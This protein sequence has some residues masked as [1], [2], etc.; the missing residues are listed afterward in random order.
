MAAEDMTSKEFED[1]SDEEKELLAA[2]ME[3]EEEAEKERAEALDGLAASIEAK[4]YQRAVRR[5]NKELEWRKCMELY[6]GNLSVDSFT[7][8]DTPFTEASKANTKPYYNVVASK[9]DI[10]IAQSIDLQ[11]AGGEKNWSL[12]ADVTEKDP[13]NLEGSR[14]MEREIQAQ[15]ER[16][17]YGRKSRRAIE[18]RVI[19]GSGILKGPVNTGKLYDAWVPIEGT[20]LWAPAAAVDNSPSIERVNPWFFYPDDTV[21]EFCQ[22]TDALEVH[23]MSAFELARLRQHPG[24]IPD[25]LAEVLKTRPEQYLN[26]SFSDYT[27]ITES[28]PY[29]FND[30]YLVI[31]YHGPILADD[32][33]K[34]SIERPAY[35]SLNGEYYGEVWVCNGKVI[36]IELEN[37]EAS[38]EIP[39]ALSTWKKDPASVFGFGSPLLMKDAQRVVREIWRMILDNA[40]I[41]SGPQV[42]LHRTYVEPA[43][44]SW[45][46]HPGKSW[47]LL[48]SSIDVQKAIQFFDV[49]NVT[50]QLLPILDRARAFAEEESMTPMI[51]GGLQGSDLSESASGQLLMKEASTTILDFLAEDWDDNITEKVIRRMYAWNMQ[52]NPR[53]DIKGNYR[54]DVRTATEYKNKQMYIRDLERLQM[55]IKQDPEASMVINKEVLFRAQLQAMHLPYEGI[56]RSDEEIEQ[57]RQQAAQQPNPQ[58]MEMQVKMKELEIKERELGLKEQQLQFELQQQQ[59]REIMDYEERMSANRAREREAEAAMVRTQNEKDIQYL[60]L[61]QKMES[62]A[63]RLRIMREIAVTN[64]ETK[65]FSEKLKADAKARDQ[66]LTVEE[67]KLKHQGKTGV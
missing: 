53:A 22:V 25:A 47:N 60:Q 52:Y 38:F 16:C 30:K 10:A 63:E 58:A 26:R 34:L 55:I 35:E 1:L 31:E 24:F 50:G 36:R 2:E 66:I 11:F 4:F 56:V 27:Q 19:I 40:S 18:D 15:L 43:N 37:I 29:L 3:S 17:G 23:P 54:V 65:M 42:A 32:L 64:N 5:R 13:R 48:D 9:C 44:G 62:D 46:L 45:Q 51:A 67:L 21:N 8:S 49:P 6:L 28:N 61:A 14:K 12:Q 33:D 7:T 20:D 57:L 39:Y 59:M 41:S